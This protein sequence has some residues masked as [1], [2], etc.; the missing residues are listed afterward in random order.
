MI[1]CVLIGW[2][3]FV[4]V[5]CIHTKILSIDSEYYLFFDIS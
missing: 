4:H 3:K 1:W 5:F 2:E